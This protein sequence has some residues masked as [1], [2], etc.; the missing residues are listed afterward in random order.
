MHTIYVH[1]VQTLHPLVRYC[2]RSARVHRRE[3]AEDNKTAL[4]RHKKKKKNRREL[5]FISNEMLSFPPSQQPIVLSFS[6]SGQ[7]TATNNT[8]QTVRKMISDLPT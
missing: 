4:A 7:G 5:K 3:L 2:S 6:S 8:F 1:H